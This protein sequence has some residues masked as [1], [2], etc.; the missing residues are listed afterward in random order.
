MTGDFTSIPVVDIAPLYDG[1]GTSRH[2]VDEAIGGACCDIGFFVVTGQSSAA[3]LD[4]TRRSRLLA[5]LDCTRE[6][7]WPIARRK[8]EPSNRNIYRGYF[9][10]I[11][12]VL[13]YKEGIDIGPELT[14]S[15]PRLSLGHPLLETNLWPPEAVVPGWRS[16]ILD[17]YAAM[18]ELGF[19]LLHAIA[20]FLALPDDWFDDKFRGGNSTLRLLRYPVRTAASVAGIEEKILRLHDGKRYEIMTAEHCDSGCLTLLHQD[21]VGGLQARNRQGDWIDVPAIDGSVVVNLGD[22]MQRWTNDLFRATEHRV[23]GSGQVR[24]SVPFFFEPAV[25]AVIAAPPGFAERGPGYPPIAYGDY[26]IE[27]V[28]RFPEFSNFLPA[29]GN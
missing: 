6:V 19:Q 27:K 29:L 15:D 18:E 21:G 23:L 11:D 17:Y 14:P 9:P 12:G 13:A 26:L 7:K 3:R 4:E 10:A 8:Y 20:R 5:F 25:D 2:T 16:A 22:L 1:D 28:Q 24:E